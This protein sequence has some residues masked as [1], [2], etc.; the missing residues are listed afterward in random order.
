MSNSSSVSKDA[1]VI[2]GASG[3][4]GR[5][6]GLALAC[7]FGVIG[8]SRGAVSKDKVHHEWRNADLTN[9]R[10]TE[11]ALTGVR[12]AVYLVHSMMPSGRA[13][14]ASFADLDLLCADNFPARRRAPVLN[15]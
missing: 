5:A 7:R 2:A 13:T 8:I 6:L 10:Q 15:K 9:L 1:V 3:F 14:R 4:I 12:Y 11:Q